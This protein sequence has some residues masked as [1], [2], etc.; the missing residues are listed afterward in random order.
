MT[1]G[2]SDV[3]MSPRREACQSRQVAGSVRAGVLQRPPARKLPKTAEDARAHRQR[4][5]GAHEGNLVVPSTLLT[6][7]LALQR[8]FLGVCCK[9]WRARLPDAMQGMLQASPCGSFDSR[10]PFAP[11]EAG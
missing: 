8:G 2:I 6:V 9:P 3:C 1:E 7:S 10:L 4:L 5:S 11:A